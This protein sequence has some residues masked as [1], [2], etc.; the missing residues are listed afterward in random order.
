MKRTKVTRRIVTFFA[1]GSIILT[2]AF[3]FVAGYITSS[4]ATNQVE[5]TF[6]NNAQFKQSGLAQVIDQ[7]AHVVEDLFASDSALQPFNDTVSAWKQMK[8]EAKSKLRRIYVDE[9]PND[10][11]NRHKLLKPEGER[12]FYHLIHSEIHPTF[13]SVISRGAISDIALVDMEGD[14]VYSYKK[15]NDFAANINDEDLKTTSRFAVLDAQK[16]L[17]AI[18]EAN[19]TAEKKLKADGVSFTGLRLTADG[20]VSASLAKAVYWGPRPVGFV[21]ITIDMKNIA[22]LIN[23]TSGIGASEK[24]YIVLEGATALELDNSGKVAS[25]VNFA[26]GIIS[27]AFASGRAI[28]FADLKSGKTQ[29]IADKLNFLGNEILLIQSIAKSDLG[30]ASRSML[31][32][33]GIVGIL[34]L[35]PVLALCWWGTNRLLAPLSHLA[36]R[37]EALR[38]GNYDARFVWDKRT[39]EIG[40]LSRILSVFRD[41]LIERD[42]LSKTQEQSQQK[43]NEKAAKLETLISN[44]R[45]EIVEALDSVAGISQSVGH[46]AS[47]LTEGSQ[48]TVGA[49]D[50]AVV[51]SVQAAQNVGAVTD[52]TSKLS[53]SLLAVK[54]QLEKNSATVDACNEK[55]RSTN[56][57]IHNLAATSDEINKVLEMISGIAEQT[58]LLALNATIEA[59]RAG[60][61][62]KGFAVVASEVKAL[63]SQTSNA[64]EQISS[65]ISTMQTAT[66]SAVD[67]VQSIAATVQEIDTETGALMEV[68]DNQ[69]TAVE[70]ISSNVQSAS[71]DTGSVQ[72]AIEQ[73]SSETHSTKIAVDDMTTASKTLQN[74][75][76]E[77]NAV[78]NSFL[79]EV[80]A[81]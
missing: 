2:A 53:S 34:C 6:A 9:N 3:L 28:A 21:T 81:A 61:S 39:D 47:Q 75:A 13:E 58:N 72:V 16:K 25:Q 76:T 67:A 43:Q 57:Q 4:T 52:T 5:T 73:I 41:N 60:E 31:L 1:L 40:H 49:T 77:L 30:A 64:T 7:S 12:D 55:A 66:S 78:I 11:F 50:E 45:N 35:I 59:A 38:Q 37:A 32:S 44:F 17:N 10:K 63:A 15:G 56:E 19:K 79:K 65:Q 69:T 18:L 74:E 22:S 8:D 27:N 29:L 42:E 70:N 48:R 54:Q 80:A 24:S 23:S 68:I 36:E 26:E 33:L 71:D 20:T 62:G 46:A 14:F 51:R